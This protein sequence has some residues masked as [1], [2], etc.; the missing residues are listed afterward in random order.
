MGSESQMECFRYRSPSRD[1]RHDSPRGPSP[2]QDKK[3]KPLSAQRIAVKAPKA[4]IQNR[5]RLCT[6][7]GAGS[8]ARATDRH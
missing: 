1:G 2:E 8:S 4:G 6:K 7:I 5:G 3:E